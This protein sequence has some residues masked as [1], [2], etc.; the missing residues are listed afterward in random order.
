[1]E[2]IFKENRINVDNACFSRSTIR[3][4]IQRNILINPLTRDPFPEELILEFDKRNY[5][6]LNGKRY[7]INTDKL[8]LSHSNIINFTPLQNLTNLE[9]LFLNFTQINELTPLQNL[10]NLKQLY[11]ISTKINDITPLQNL[12]NLIIL[13]LS[14]T[15]I[16]DITPLQNLTNLIKLNLSDTKIYNFYTITK[17]S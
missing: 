16:T 13:D 17:F 12:T 4:L 7:D 15:Q 3:D 2:P 11:M 9:Y 6:I 5:V 8:D 1:M 10:T 14:N